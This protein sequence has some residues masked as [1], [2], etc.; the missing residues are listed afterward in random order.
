MWHNRCDRR[1]GLAGPNIVERV[2]VNSADLGAGLFCGGAKPF[3]LVRRV[4]PGIVAEHL[5]LSERRGEPLRRWFL[6]QVMDLNRARI[7][8]GGCLQC[9]APID[10]ERCAVAHNDREAC[11]PGEAGQPG[12]T[13]TPWR[14]VFPLMLVGAR[15]DEP[16]EFRVTPFSSV[17]GRVAP[18]AAAE[19][20]RRGK[21]RHGTRRPWRPAAPRERRRAVAASGRRRARASWSRFRPGRPA[22]PRPS[23]RLLRRCMQNLPPSAIAPSRPGWVGLRSS[24]STVP[25][26]LHG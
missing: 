4:Q 2:I 6:Y 26:S 10:K 8:L 9:V 19:R 23:P 25:F 11:R 22:R 5:A 16:I 20:N 13:L 1:C 17:G 15:H 24:S 3:H 21:G 18:T 12:E 7:N 14:H